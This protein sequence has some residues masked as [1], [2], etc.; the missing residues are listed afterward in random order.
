MDTIK[1]P[2]TTNPKGFQTFGVLV[3][4]K[5]AVTSLLISI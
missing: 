4:K 2:S 1:I 5:K 3:F